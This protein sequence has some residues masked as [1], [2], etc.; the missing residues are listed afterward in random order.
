MKNPTI[1][2]RIRLGDIFK[3]PI[4]FPKSEIKDPIIKSGAKLQ[5]EGGTPKEKYEAMLKLHQEIDAR[6]C[7]QLKTK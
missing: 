4:D 5:F 7:L 2:E 3:K 6:V 1:F